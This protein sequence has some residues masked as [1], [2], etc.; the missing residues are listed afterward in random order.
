MDG[1]RGERGVHRR[2][3]NKKVLC[4]NVFF[5]EYNSGCRVENRLGGWGIEDRRSVKK[6]LHLL[7]R[8]GDRLG[9]ALKIGEKKHIFLKKGTGWIRYIFVFIEACYIIAKGGKDWNVHQ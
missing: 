9:E 8:D 2:A 1:R 7:I 5:K 4:I 6:P 3:L